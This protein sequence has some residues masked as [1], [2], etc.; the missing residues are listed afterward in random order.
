MQKE[1]QSKLS[2]KGKVTMTSFVIGD[3]EEA[4]QLDNMLTQAENI[5]PE[6]F[7]TAI[8]RLKEL[9]SFREKAFNNRIVATGRACFSGRLVGET[10]YTGTINYGALGTGSTAVADGDTVLDTEVKRKAVATR[11][12]TGN[13]VTMR[14]FYSKSDTDGTY[15]EFGTFIDG[16]GIVDTGQL[17]NRVLTGGWV[18][19][20]L[21]SL[22]VTVQFDLNAA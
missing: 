5:E 6:V 18:K 22:T 3:N 8:A 10:T 4:Q 9:C 15:E 17:F 7:E 2:W 19:S 1:V 12:R 13:T 16:T 21:E 11:S 14:F 20:D